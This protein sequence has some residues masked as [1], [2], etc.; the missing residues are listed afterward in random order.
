MYP[1]PAVVR[2]IA[3]LACLA[4]PVSSLPIADY[5]FCVSD[6]QK[7]WNL[8]VF[9]FL[10]FFAHAATVPSISGADWRINGCHTLLVLLFPYIGLYYSLSLI[11]RRLVF[12]E[13]DLRQA[14]AANSV[15]VV[16]RTSGWKPP[17]DRRL[18]TWVVLPENYDNLDAK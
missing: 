11:A 17:S 3:V 1:T 13:N 18:R 4:I 2:A 12:D 6:G 5:A 15:V 10:N 8:A 16:S 14:I 9:L 7:Y